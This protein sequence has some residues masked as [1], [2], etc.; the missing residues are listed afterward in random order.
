MRIR[1]LGPA[2]LV[3]ALLIAALAP[4][5]EAQRPGGGKGPHRGQG[6]DRAG[7][8]EELGPGEYALDGAA[9]TEALNVGPV[10]ALREAQIE[11]QR[12]F[13]HPFVWAAFGLAGASR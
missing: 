2:L 10:A 4:L 3:G 5:A 6:Q 1:R 12:A 9:A 11:T 7:T 8:Q 13:P